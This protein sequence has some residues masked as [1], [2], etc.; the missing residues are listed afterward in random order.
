M[1]TPNIEISP[2]DVAR[3]Y[4]ELDPFYRR[5]WGEHVH[6][7]LWFDGLEEPEEA[8]EQ[9]I[10]A[11]IAPL[12][13]RMG[14]RLV[15]IGCGYG[16]T[17]RYVA[18]VAGAQVTGLTLSQ[19]QA[20]YA[21]AAAAH[22]GSDVP[23]PEILVQDWTKN[24]FAPDS[25]DAAVSIECLAHVVDKAAYFA[26]IR[27]V[28]KPGSRASLAVWLSGDGATPWEH[29]H[30]LEPICREGRLPSMGTAFDYSLLIAQA[31]LRVVA[32]HD[33]TAHVEQT[34]SLCAA[35]SIVFALTS[36]EAWRY[37]ASGA[38]KNAIFLLT[39]FRLLLAY[40]TGAMRYGLLVLEKPA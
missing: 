17:A 32:F 1:I 38:S 21:R 12:R 30:L 33:V 11:V 5:L 40:R 18:R 19:A 36:P 8:T 15:D 10:D 28:L 24:R 23:V 25:F 6:H 39:I 14:D 20:D 16:G 34:W 27:R 37:L 22:L 26:E 13:L 9:L 7:G 4:D 2:Q 35:R 3:H 31:G 29:R